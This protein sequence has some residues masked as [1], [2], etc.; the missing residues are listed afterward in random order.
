MDY[1]AIGT[2]IRSLSEGMVLEMQRVYSLSSLAVDLI[3]W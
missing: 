3:Q 2:L 1:F